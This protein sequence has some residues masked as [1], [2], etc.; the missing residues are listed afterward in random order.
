MT[1]HVKGNIMTKEYET[2]FFFDC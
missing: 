1:S 2:W